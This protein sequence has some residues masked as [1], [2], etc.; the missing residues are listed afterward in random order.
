MEMTTGV[1][2]Q[3]GCQDCAA[4]YVGQTGR[5]LSTRIKE[6]VSLDQCPP[7]SIC[8]GRTCYGHRALHRLEEHPGEAVMPYFWQRCTL[9]TWH[10]RSQPHPL[11]HKEGILPHVYD[12]LIRPN[13][14]PP[15]V[16]RTSSNAELTSG[17]VPPVG[18]ASC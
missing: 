9:E 2:Y 5:S 8:R 6:H 16:H 4:T 13:T 14:P 17:R 10:M 18:H 11:N 3:I 12:A 15:R 1:V 7:R